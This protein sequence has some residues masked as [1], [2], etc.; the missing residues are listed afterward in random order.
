MVFYYLF[1]QYVTWLMRFESMLF[2]SFTDLSKPR[3]SEFYRERMLYIEDFAIFMIFIFIF[4][5][6][7]FLWIQKV[8]R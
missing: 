1:D 2:R 5:F 8:H 7:I 3:S 6:I 4:Y